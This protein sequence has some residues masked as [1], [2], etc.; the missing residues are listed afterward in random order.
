MQQSVAGHKHLMMDYLDSHEI[1]MN[2]AAIKQSKDHFWC[3][4]QL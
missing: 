2:M 3:C 4:M 1:L